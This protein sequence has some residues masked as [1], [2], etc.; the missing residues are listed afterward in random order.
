MPKSLTQDSLVARVRYPG[1]AS[2]A[3][4]GTVQHCRRNPDGGQTFTPLAF[5][6]ARPA[7]TLSRIMPRSNSANTPGIRNIASLCQMACRHQ[8]D[9]TPLT[10]CEP[11]RSRRTCQRAGTFF[12]SIATD[13]DA[14]G[15][16]SEL[17]GT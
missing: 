4:A 6:R 13:Q 10:D 9:R 1:Q 3:I 8:C 12:A 17:S 16:R 7:L 5:A 2:R 11:G 15:S 14:G